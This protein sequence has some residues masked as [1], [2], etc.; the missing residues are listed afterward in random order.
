MERRLRLSG[1]LTILGLL[2][3]AVSL[4]RVHPLYFLSFM[5]VG[6]GLLAAG[7]AIYLYALVA[8]PPPAARGPK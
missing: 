7:I 5:F 4:V 3:E 1:T 6:G 2:V 8:A